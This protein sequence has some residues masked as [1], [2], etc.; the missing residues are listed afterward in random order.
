MF[1]LDEIG[2]ENDS[3]TSVLVGRTSTEVPNN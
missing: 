1:K 2:T 3:T